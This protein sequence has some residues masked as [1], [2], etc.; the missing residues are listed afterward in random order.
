MRVMREGLK[1]RKKQSASACQLAMSFE[2][3]KCDRG[4]I[5]RR[6]YKEVKMYSESGMSESAIRLSRYSME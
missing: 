2:C 4:I 3:D 5:I 6:D 1:E